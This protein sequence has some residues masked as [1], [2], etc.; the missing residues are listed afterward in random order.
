MKVFEL[1]EPRIEFHSPMML[2]MFSRIV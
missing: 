2:R 1:R